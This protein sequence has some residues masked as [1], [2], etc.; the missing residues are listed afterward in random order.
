MIDPFLDGTLHLHFA[1]PINIVGSRLII[2]GFG[3]QSV[4]FSLRHILNFV[5]VVAIYLKP[6]QEFMVE[7]NVFFPR[8]ANL[9]H[10]GDFHILVI[11]VH[12]AATH[13]YWTEDRLDTRSGLRHQTGCTGR[14]DGQHR[15]VT[16]TILNHCLIERRI[17]FADTSNHRVILFA[18]SIINREC[19]PFTSQLNRS[20]ICFESQCFLNLNCKIDRSFG[21]ILQAESCQ[22][23]A[24]RRN[25]Q[26]GTTSLL[27]FGT[28]FL[29]KI[30]LY[31][32]DILIFRILSNLFQNQLNLF[33]FEVD[34]IVHH[35]HGQCNVLFEAVEIELS[36]FGK[37]IVHVTIEIHSHQ[38]ATVV[39][40]QRNLTA[41]VGRNRTET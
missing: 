2:G 6:Y 41:R 33:Q 20:A 11:G 12:F 5:D 30:L 36:T 35:A 9:I 27:S 15:D 16:T 28:D 26:T 29:P 14:S 38:T 18:F 25:T 23:I 13:I 31:T 39:W 21:A 1:Y 22:H 10:K 3:Y 34:N 7:D 8:V 37:R 24:F 4:Q 17:S 40:A 32:T 19:P